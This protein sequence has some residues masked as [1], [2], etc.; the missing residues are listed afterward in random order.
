M[1]RAVNR[2]FPD[3][4]ADTRFGFGYVLSGKHLSGYL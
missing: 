2:R 1:K 3:K 4:R